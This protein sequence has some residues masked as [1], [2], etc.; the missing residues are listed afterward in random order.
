MRRFA[1]CGSIVKR[2]ASRCHDRAI[3]NPLLRCRTY[4]KRFR[5]R[6]KFFCVVFFVLV[7]LPGANC[8]QESNAQ[9]G[10]RHSSRDLLDVISDGYL[11]NRESFKFLTCKYKVT[12]GKVS[13]VE[14][15]RRGEIVDKKTADFLWIV[16]GHKT[17]LEKGFDPDLLEIERNDQ[18]K[19][20][21]GNATFLPEKFVSNGPMHLRYAPFINVA[22][23]NGPVNPSEGVE[24]TPFDM[25]IMGPDEK[26]SPG[27]VLSMDWKPKKFFLSY[28]GSEK[29]ERDSDIRI[30]TLRRSPE[31]VVYKYCLDARRGF[32][33]VEHW[34]M[35]EEGRMMF[36]LFITS[37]ENSAEVGWFPMRSILIWDPESGDKQLTVRE[38]I[39][40][41]LDVTN[42]PKESDFAIVLPKKT[43]V[44][45]GVLAKTQFSLTEDTTIRL[46]D[47]P[48]LYG[49]CQQT[50]AKQLSLE[51]HLG[52]SKVEESSTRYVLIIVNGVLVVLVLLLVR[53]VWK[54]YRLKKS[55][56]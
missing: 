4:L 10:N 25:G 53:H 13:S 48:T 24:L 8:A 41:K 21:V 29:K 5:M 15:A 11:H 32:L 1:I 36:R 17:L 30:V 9:E 43:F 45:D 56:R 2:R 46:V 22:S 16:D 3:G 40:T 31:E 42:R 37:I 49:R 20:K 33:P 23:V 14:S 47:L 50:L 35:N 28:D 12:V 34:Q 7:L 27:R 26:F 52:L 55:T 51:S 19:S 54:R 38:I 6:I 39:V 44:N 18:A